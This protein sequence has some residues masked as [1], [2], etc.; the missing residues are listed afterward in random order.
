MAITHKKGD[1]LEWVV[2]LTESL[3]PS[4]ITAWSIR[5]HI[6]DSSDTLLQAL[7]VTVTN[8]A[9]G[10]FS[11]TATDTQ[12]A[13]WA[14]GTYQIDIEFTNGAGLVFSTN[15]FDLNVVQDISHD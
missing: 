6:R 8:A 3:V 7:T 12:T 4:N 1:D 2:N 9:G 5:A 13:T 10:V 14:V 11:L 15:T